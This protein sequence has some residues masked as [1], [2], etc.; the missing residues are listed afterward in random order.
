MLKLW[1]FLLRLSEVTAKNAEKDVRL[2]KLDGVLKTLE[3][4]TI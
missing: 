2:L 3:N 1:T 4:K